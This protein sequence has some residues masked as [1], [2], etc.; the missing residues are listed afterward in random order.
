MLAAASPL[1]LKRA[2]CEHLPASRPCLLLP[3]VV[4]VKMRF[5]FTVLCSVASGALADSFLSQGSAKPGAVE[6]DAS[7]TS[8]VLLQALDA[9]CG[10]PCE[11]VLQSA[12]DA[13]SNKTAST[14]CRAPLALMSRQSCYV[15]L[16]C[17]PVG[18]VAERLS[19]AGC[20]P[21]SCQ[22]SVCL[23]GFALCGQAF[24]RYRFPGAS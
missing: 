16:C 3:C 18:P 17:Y 15:A 1:C 12:F 6:V 13:V 24:R 19:A 22:C 10:K 21:A 5:S 14:V 4:C 20:D 7:A 23:F 2:V 9:G 8:P 11:R